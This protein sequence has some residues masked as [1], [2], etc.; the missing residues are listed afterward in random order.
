MMPVIATMPVIYPHNN[1]LALL[2]LCHLVSPALPVGAYAYSQGLEYAVHCN[3]VHDEA[4]AYEWLAGLV[5]HSIGTL[6]L[7]ILVRSFRAWTTTDAAALDSWNEQ[8]IAS[9]ETD[10]LRAEE[11]HLG[12]ALARVLIGL[13]I[14]QARPWAAPRQTAFCTVFALAAMY[15]EIAERDM[16]CGYAW[17]WCENQ[18]LAAVKL[19]PLGQ[20]AGQRLV[21]RLAQEIPA[22]AERAL[23]MNDADVGV[24]VVAQSLGSALHEGQYSRLFRS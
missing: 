13:D 4:S 11:R 15:W 10:E 16:A 7:P 9:R 14:D 21:H 2:R 22:I 24:G 6:D 20:S 12:A 17:A 19:V 3:W 1:S 8:L 18:V 5:Q 23:T